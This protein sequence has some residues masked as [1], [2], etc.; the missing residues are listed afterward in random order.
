MATALLS[1]TAKQQFLLD[2]GTPA[3]GAKL[4]TYAANSTTP[5]ATYMNR[6]GTV[7][8][9][10]PIILDARG[11]AIMYLTPGVVYDYHLYTA[12]DVLI[13]TRE[14][15][16]ADAGDADA[17]AFLQDGS[18]AVVR[19][20]QSRLL[21][22]VS[23]KDFGAEGDGVTDD[24]LAITNAL[25]FC[26]TGNARTLFFPPGT[27]C[28]STNILIQRPLSLKGS[29]AGYP[30]YV[31]TL[32][33]T[34]GTTIKWT[35]ASYA[36]AMFNFNNIDYG[37]V[38]IED[39]TIDAD[40][41]ADYTLLIDNVVGWYSKNLICRNYRFVGLTLRATGAAGP[42]GGKTMSFS[43]FINTTLQSGVTTAKAGLWLTGNTGQGN[44]CH[45]AFYSTNIQ[46]GGASHGIYLGGCDNISMHMTMIN[47]APG[48]TGYGVYVDPTEMT[49]FPI[50]N[51][52]YHL[53]SMRGWY[54]PASTGVE[55]AH[56]YH[57]ST[58]NGQ[59]LPITNGTN[60]FYITDRMQM[61]GVRSISRGSVP[62]QGS[63]LIHDFT[64]PSGTANYTVTLPNTEL[65]ANY[66]ILLSAK[67]SGVLP[68]HNISNKTTTS[69]RVDMTPAAATDVPCDALM[70][71]Y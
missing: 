17:I 61:C 24:T 56:I 53:Q 26:N 63:N 12:D 22:T 32:A 15:I 48:T 34:V 69:Y 3:A 29:G 57:Y 70:I 25:D 14:D 16:I 71:R 58:D 41:L 55:P 38:G 44:A 43:T 11:E 68:P 9:T 18:G 46:H 62:G 35:G 67:G 23:V 59:P 20:I 65:D 33:Q 42:Y 39:I 10:N 31:G 64:I 30:G 37:S 19:S 27:Y 21:D 28:I 52:F 60:L 54:Q 13:Y 1:P 66:M 51:S 50:G 36:G 49:S 6:A 4:F 5:Q 47:G 8:N 45:V 40:S 7:A 2:D